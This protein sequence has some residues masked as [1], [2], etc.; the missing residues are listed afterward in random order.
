MY[1]QNYFTTEINPVLHYF[2]ILHLLLCASSQFDVKQN[3]YAHTVMLKFPLSENQTFP[4]RI[5]LS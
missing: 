4:Q 2:N 3:K 5:F 1:F